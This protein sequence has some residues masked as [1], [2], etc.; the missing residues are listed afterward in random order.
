[1]ATSDHYSL[2]ELKPETGR[3]HQLRVHLNHLR[4]PIVGDV[5]YGGE[6]ANRLYLHA[7]ELE[8]TI[9]QGHE[10]KIFRAHTPPEFQEKV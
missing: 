4:R 5:L 2:V 6:P 1:V 9:L 3:T 7:K 10:R 8:I